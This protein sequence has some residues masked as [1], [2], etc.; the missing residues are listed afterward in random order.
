MAEP[1]LL[2]RAGLARLRRAHARRNHSRFN[3]DGA[4]HLLDERERAALRQLERQTVV[5]AGVIGALS[6]GALD[7]QRIAQEETFRVLAPAARELPNPRDNPLALD[8]LKETPRWLLVDAALAYSLKVSAT[9]I[10]LTQ[11]RAAAALPE[12]R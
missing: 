10:I 8:P 4:V 6:A 7:D 5:R 3:D 1:S 12:S 11:H 2:E 9:N